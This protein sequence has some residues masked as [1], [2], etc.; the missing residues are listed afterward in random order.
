M[1][2]SEIDDILNYGSKEEMEKLKCPSCNGNIIYKLDISRLRISCVKCNEVYYDT[3]AYHANCVKY[4]GREYLFGSG[5]KEEV[6]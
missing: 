3:G 2:W 5:Q 4:Y 6:L 1:T